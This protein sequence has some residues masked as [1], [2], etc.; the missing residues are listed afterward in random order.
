MSIA[1]LWIKWFTHWQFQRGS[2]LK[3]FAAPAKFFPQYIKIAVAG[4]VHQRQPVVAF[5]DPNFVAGQ[6]REHNMAVA[7]NL[8][9]VYVGFGYP[10]GNSAVSVNHNGPAT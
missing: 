9:A 2:E 8:Y 3:Q 6:G 1:L 10:H 5:S 4:R 7:T